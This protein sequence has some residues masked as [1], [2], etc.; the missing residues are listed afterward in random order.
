M[1]RTKKADDVMERAR[2]AASQL[3]PV[4]EQVKPIA[5]NTGDAAKRQ[6]R[7]TRAWA[8]PQVERS[9]QVLQEK[10]APKVAA[11]LSTAAERIDPARPSRR[12]W[13]IPA[14]A[15]LAAAAGGA[16]AYFKR[17]GQAQSAIMPEPSEPAS[18]GQG[19][20]SDA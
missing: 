11:M 1:S 8:A 9:G 14:A 12:R 6:V 15:S 18:N 4:A 3:K 13:K 16:A 5:K 20:G 7:K 10:V 17:R 2:S 19:P